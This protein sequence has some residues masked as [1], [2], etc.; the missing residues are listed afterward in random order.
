MSAI[1]KSR[2]GRS[3]RN[4]HSCRTF[5]QNASADAGLL[6][7]LVFAASAAV[8][9]ILSLLAEALRRK[10]APP[11]EL[12]WAPD[13]PIIYAHVNGHRIRYV[14]VGNG[15]TL[16]LLHTLRTQLDLFEKVVEKLAR[17]FTVYA[18]DYPGHGYSDNPDVNYDAGF[19]A[20][21]VEGFL[22]ALALENVCLQPV[23]IAW[24]DVSR[25]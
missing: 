3:R 12:R 21:S 14:K 22:D 24:R 23:G 25:R 15:P 9:I 18:L 10:P 6:I 17:H 16:V 19:F 7:A 1:D 5:R 11:A 2:P 13:M 4:T 8:V 20:G